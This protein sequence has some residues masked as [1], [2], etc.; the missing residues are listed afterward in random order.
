MKKAIREPQQERSIEK[1][2]KIIE[3][4][5]VLFSENGYYS[6]GTSDIAKK[7]G[8]STGIVYGYF[9]DKRDILLY[10]LKIYIDRVTAPLIDYMKKMKAPVDFKKVL[11]EFLDLVTKT[12]KENAHLHNTLH[13]LAAS[14]KD[15][16]GEFIALED[17]I[18]EHVS[19]RLTELG[20]NGEHISEKVHIAMNLMQS[21]S[22]EAI[23]DRHKYIDYEAMRQE[24]LDMLAKLF[25]E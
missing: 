13:S 25:S 16:S 22:H 3:A 4:S 2:N 21:F 11:S 12:H 19:N 17:R 18:T 1:K 8:V 5:Y 10:V 9:E 15:V 7:A 14:D 23:F 20:V 24:V 6:T